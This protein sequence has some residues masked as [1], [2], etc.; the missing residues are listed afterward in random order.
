MLKLILTCEHGGNNIPADLEACFA[1]HKDV[2]DTHRGYD[3]GALTLFNQLKDL[4]D[5]AYYSETSRLLIEL[6]RSLNH[7]DLFSEFT[8][9]LP[10]S[11]KE[12][13]IREYYTPY[14]QQVEGLIEDFVRADRQVLHI[15]V[16]T[17]TPTLNGKQREADI[18]LLY[19]PKRQQERELCRKWKK[20]LQWQ[21]K[22]LVV[23]YNYPY[24]GKADGF[25]THLRKKYTA[26]E[27]IGVELEVNQ[28]FAI[29]NPGTWQAVM[30]SVKNS[31]VALLGKYRALE[32]D[33]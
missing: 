28:K 13:L 3:I 16:H 20:E 7:K 10:Q 9:P 18:G 17:F 30:Q 25:P 11:E 32:N 22:N 21:D 26:K 1:V 4:A 23:R 33:E 31:L 8:K 12:K 15:S 19:D 5:K 14:R 24:L 2:L 29:A 27:Y 6:N